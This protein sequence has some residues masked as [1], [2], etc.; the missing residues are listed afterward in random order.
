MLTIQGLTA[1]YPD[2]TKAVDGIDLIVNDGESVA[3]IG[4]NGAGKT[5]LLLAVVGVIESLSGVVEI[6]GVRL[7]KKTAG[8]I[9][10]KAGLVFQNPDDQLFMPLIYDD[11]AFGCRNLGMPED[12]VKARVADVLD[13]LNI[14]HLRGR[15]PL[16]LSGGEKRAVAM[17]AVLAM[18]PSLLMLDEPT[19][20]LDHRAR[21]SLVET[22]KKLSQTKIIATHDIAFAAEVC[23]RAVILKDGKIAVDGAS[24]LLYDEKLMS[25]YRLEAIAKG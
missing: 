13:R 16:K 22:L 7:G 25:D 2:K 1:I 21:R 3:L 15:S 24:S 19:A 20:F 4:E 23:D 14:A 8:E 5:S 17:A 6:D 9:R 12:E 10:K 18:N 11:I